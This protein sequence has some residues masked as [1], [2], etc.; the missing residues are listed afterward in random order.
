MTPALQLPADVATGTVVGRFGSVDD[1]LG[2]DAPDMVVT[3]A[4]MVHTMVTAEPPVRL[5]LV[6]AVCS[7]DSDGFLCGPNGG[8]GVRLVAG[9]YR[10]L[11]SPQTFPPATVTVTAGE[12]LDI[13]RP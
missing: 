9:V 7:L 13:G 11:F 1:G 3:F 10:L 4:A 5:M 6:P 2:L 8:R 12:T